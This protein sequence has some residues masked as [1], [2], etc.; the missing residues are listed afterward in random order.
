MVELQSYLVAGMGVFWGEDLG[1][2]S[3]LPL[4]IYPRRKLRYGFVGE[5]LFF[6]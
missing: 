3:P 2:R 6:F 1:Q 5:S 4:A